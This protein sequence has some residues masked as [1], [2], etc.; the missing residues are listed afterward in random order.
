MI[1][2]RLV[3]ALRI[4]IPYCK[5]VSGLGST[6]RRRINQR[7]KNSNTY[8]AP[9]WKYPVEYQ[10]RRTTRMVTEVIHSSFRSWLSLRGFFKIYKNSGDIIKK[11][12]PQGLAFRNGATR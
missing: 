11:L 6:P 1:Q 7:G 9:T 5:V 12:M 4:I 2:K 10:L 8:R 3:H